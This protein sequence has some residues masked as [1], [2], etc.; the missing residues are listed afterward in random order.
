MTELQHEVVSKVKSHCTYTDAANYWAPL[1]DRDEDDDNKHSNAE[2]SPHVTINNLSNA[3]VQRNLRSTIMAWIY[4]RMGKH[5]PFQRKPSTMVLDSGATSSFVRPEENLPIIG[6][7]SK[8]VN[9]PDGRSIQATH[10]TMLPFESLAVEARRADV[11][12]GL[13]PNSLVSVGKLADADYTTI[14]HPH[15]EGVTIHKKDSFRL[16][17]YRKPV[18]QGW[19]DTNGLWRLSRDNKPSEWG[20]TSRESNIN[21]EAA[22]NVYNLPSIPQS[23]AYLHAAAGFPPKDTWTKAIKHGNYNTW[24]GLTVEAVN[25]HFPE[26]VETQKGHMKKQRQHVR[27]TKQK[28]PVDLTPENEEL[29]QT[30]PKHNILV[31]VINASE[32]VYRS[33]GT[34]ASAVQP[35]KY[36]TH[37]V[38]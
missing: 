36:L 21:K 15:G 12:P 5:K 14:F 13:R 8:I 19:R 37:G 20:R 33:D 35:G 11:L 32:T 18:L 2:S 9:L 29:T 22:A 6:L 17:L 10:T 24:P 34:F 3:K 25:R 38:L 16:K 27:S 26:S 28:T 30:L 31:K 4:H 23:I 1:A 7:S